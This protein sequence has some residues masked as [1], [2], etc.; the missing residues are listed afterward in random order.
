MLGE[1]ASAVTVTELFVALDDFHLAADGDSIWDND[2]DQFSM[3]LGENTHD[4]DT[5]ALVSVCAASPLFLE[6]TVARG[7]CSH[8]P[9]HKK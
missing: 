3:I 7:L 4:T 6:S 8:P 9:T 2:S 1:A 5:P